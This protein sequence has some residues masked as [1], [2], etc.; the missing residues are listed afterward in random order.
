[1]QR[2]R[3]LGATKCEVQAASADARTTVLAKTSYI[4]LVIAK[5]EGDHKGNHKKERE[6]QSLVHNSIIKSKD[7]EISKANQQTEKYYNVATS[8]NAKV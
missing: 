7:Y 4:A 8:A 5:R 3:R 2:I 1:M 6:R